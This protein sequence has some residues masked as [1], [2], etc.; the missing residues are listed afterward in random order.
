MGECMS[1]CVCVW[2]G[3]CV[4]G[5]VCVCVWLSECVY[6]CVCVCVCM[7]STEDLA[8]SRVEVNMS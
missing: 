7:V 8:T 5:C 1:V 4:S 2:V 3:L 6:V